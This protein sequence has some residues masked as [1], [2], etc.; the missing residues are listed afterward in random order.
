MLSRRSVRIKVMQILYAISKD[1][2]QNSKDGKKIY[3]DKIDKSYD[4]FLFNVYSM[5]QI[6]KVSTE[7]EERRKAKHLPDDYDKS[8]TDK[9]VTN[10]L[11]SSLR[12]NPF[13]LK[14]Y[15]SRHFPSM[16]D[17]D[18]YKK[19]YND[20]AKTDE[21]KAYVTGDQN[22]EGHVELLLELYR[23]CRKSELFK[24]LMEDNFINWV[25]DKSMVIGATKKVLKAL[26]IETET[27]IKQYYPDDETVKQFGEELLDSCLDGDEYLSSLIDPLLK[28][29]DS[30][31]VASIDMILLK[32]AA[33]E[34]LNFESIPC[35]VSINE[36]V[37]VAKAYS[38]DKSKE[39][40][41]GVLDKLMKDL[42]EQ[43]K[44][45]KKGRGLIND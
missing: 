15:D 35:K 4:L 14:A 36:Y 34:M 37:D 25:D 13:L 45:D 41:N 22:H 7:D 27:D 31:R 2:T 19:I 28:N 20:F 18:H 30:D 44:I 12:D 6:A 26:P 3:W 43:G 39:F 33:S 40:V 24:E 38:T 17:A 10:E 9:L 42:E 23:F 11:M 5:L 21:Y 29:W 32:M 16:V 1:D 8:F